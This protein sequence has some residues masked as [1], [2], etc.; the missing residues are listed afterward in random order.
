MR[1]V[2]AGNETLRRGFLVSRR[3]VD[4]AGEKQPGDALRFESPRQLRRLDEVVLDGVAGP[5]QHR[6]FETRQRVHQLGLAR[7][8]AGT[9][10]I[11]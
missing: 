5:Q 9:S 2:D 3:P 4:L 10:K 7:R 8:A 11:R 6:V 1:G